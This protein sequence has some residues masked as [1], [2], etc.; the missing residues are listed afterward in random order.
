MLPLDAADEPQ[1]GAYDIA[2]CASREGK[3]NRPPPPR[4]GRR[5]VIQ[6]TVCADVGGRTTCLALNQMRCLSS[7]DGTVP[8]DLR[9]L[10]GRG[11]GWGKYGSNNT[12]GRGGRCTTWRRGHHNNSNRV[13]SNTK[14]CY[15]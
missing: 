8:S 1:G 9:A 11:A 10:G 2:T 12:G 13:T 14:H 7:D 5:A 3:R 6:K 15:Y 4:T